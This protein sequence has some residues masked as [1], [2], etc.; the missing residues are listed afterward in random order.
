MIQEKTEKIQLFIKHKMPDPFSNAQRGETD[1]Y[2]D[3]SLTPY[4]LKDPL[5]M[6]QLLSQFEIAMD[7]AILYVTEPSPATVY[8]RACCVFTYPIMNNLIKMNAIT[9]PSGLVDTIMM[10]VYASLEMMGGDLETELYAQERVYKMQRSMTPS[11]LLSYF[12]K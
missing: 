11:K 12:A 7:V 3:Y 2:D 4:K 5:P 9:N 1:Y 6:D 10:T 8:G